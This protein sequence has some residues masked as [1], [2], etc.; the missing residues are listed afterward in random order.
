MS[1]FGPPCPGCTPALISA[2]IARHPEVYTTCSA[3][4]ERGA[5]YH[6]QFKGQRAD[7]VGDVTEKVEA[8]G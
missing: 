5:L 3:C 6:A 4:L 1:D 7:H 8:H 2:R